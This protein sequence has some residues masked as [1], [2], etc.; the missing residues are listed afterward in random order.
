MSHFTMND[1][2]MVKAICS[3]SFYGVL[4]GC[5]LMLAMLCVFVLYWNLE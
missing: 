2:Q 5:K 4:E 1:S 3:H